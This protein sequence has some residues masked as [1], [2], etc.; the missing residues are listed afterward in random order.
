M[1]AWV[2]SE[3]APYTENAPGIEAVGTIIEIGDRCKYKVGDR[4]VTTT[5]RAGRD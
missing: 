5:S 4:I 3:S 2:I 1:K